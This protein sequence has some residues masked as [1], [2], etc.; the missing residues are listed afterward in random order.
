MTNPDEEAFEY[1]DEPAHRE[2]VAAAAHYGC[3]ASLSF[4][5]T[6][7]RRKSRWGESSTSK[8]TAYDT[9]WSGAIVTTLHTDPGQHSVH[10]WRSCS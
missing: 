9:G 2:P 4:G 7:R 5:G 3:K 10:L 1:Y 6:F 8:A